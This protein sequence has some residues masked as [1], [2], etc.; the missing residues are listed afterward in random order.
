[1]LQ[2]LFKACALPSTTQKRGTR[3][4]PKGW[5]AWIKNNHEH[6]TTMAIKNDEGLN[7][8]LAYMKKDDAHHCSVITF[9]WSSCSSFH[10]TQNKRETPQAMGLNTKWPWLTRNKWQGLGWACS[11]KKD[12]EGGDKSSLTLVENGLKRTTFLS[13]LCSWACNKQW[14]WQM[15]HNTQPW[16][17]RKKIRYPRVTFFYIYMTKLF[18]HSCIISVFIPYL[19]LHACKCKHNSK[20]LH[21]M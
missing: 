14:L 10:N 4:A 11:P 18:L 7:G 17:N 5:W 13:S 12:D 3:G 2:L 6:K 8:E 20:C 16:K 21:D 1:M 9:P 15:L 19:H